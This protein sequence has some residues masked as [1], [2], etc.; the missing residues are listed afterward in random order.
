MPVHVG[1]RYWPPYVHDVLRVMAEQGLRNLLA[2][3]LSPFQCSASWEAYQQV[4]GRA[5]QR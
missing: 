2:V 5:W 1:M 3:I 4:V